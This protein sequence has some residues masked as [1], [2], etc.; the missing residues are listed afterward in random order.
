LAAL[1]IPV[2]GET[3]MTSFVMISFT[4]SMATFYL[5]EIVLVFRGDANLL[6]SV[7]FNRRLH[8]FIQILL[9]NYRTDSFYFRSI[10]FDIWNQIHLAQIAIFIL[11]SGLWLS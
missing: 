8:N 2:S 6:A 3:E 10:I 1:T 7:G 11:R 4:L 5:F 9:K